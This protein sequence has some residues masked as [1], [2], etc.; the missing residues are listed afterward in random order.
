LL[1]FGGWSEMATLSGEVQDARHGMVRALIASILVI[2]LLYVLAN[3]A[4]VR[5][6]GVEGLARSQA[7]AADL[8]A[9][10]FGQEAGLILAIAVA[11]AAITSINAT[12]VVG[13]R[14]TAAAALDTPS[15]N[16]L[17]R[18]DD[19][20]GIPRNA[21]WVQSLIA[22]G[23]VVF[24]AVY[25]GFSTLV[26]YTAPVYWTFLMGSGL[27]LMILR[28]KHPVTHRPFSVPLYPILP[29]LFTLSSFAMLVSSLLYV[30]TGA[31]FGVA[32][33]GFG[34]ILML[35]ARPNRNA[36]GGT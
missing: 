4:M 18:W 17:G 32:V 30:K 31:F 11:A 28:R 8:M 33:L 19:I 26:D 13:A 23:L 21:I 36:N 9:R 14:T 10:A 3:W 29:I 25:E 7:P 27:S 20:R 6:L 12:I 1:A 34:A 5:G 24:G 15:L 35:W 22:M 16:W 2:T